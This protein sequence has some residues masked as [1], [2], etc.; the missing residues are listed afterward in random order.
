MYCNIEGTMNKSSVCTEG[1]REK[2]IEN[3]NTYRNT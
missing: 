2:K 3:L 1:G